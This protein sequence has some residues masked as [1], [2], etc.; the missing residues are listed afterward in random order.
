M[1]DYPKF[2]ITS[3]LAVLVEV[4]QGSTG[5]DPKSLKMAFFVSDSRVLKGFLSVCW[6]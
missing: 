2:G 6:K 1:I 5:E 4:A 3:R